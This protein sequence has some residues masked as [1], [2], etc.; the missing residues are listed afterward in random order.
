MPTQPLQLDEAGAL[1]PYVNATSTWVHRC[2]KRMLELDP[3]LDPL[4]AMHTVDDMATSSRWRLMLPEAVA[5]AL[6]ADH[7]SAGPLALGHRAKP[8]S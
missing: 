3:S 4:A 1:F 8:S 6:Y 2:A 7:P 5:E